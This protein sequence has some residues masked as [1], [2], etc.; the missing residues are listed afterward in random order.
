[1]QSTTKAVP[2][3]QLQ[4]ISLLL[5]NLLPEAHKTK[6]F[7]WRSGHSSIICFHCWEQPGHQSCGSPK[8]GS[9]SR[10]A[11]PRALSPPYSSIPSPQ[12][13]RCLSFP[14]R[15]QGSAPVFIAFSAMFCANARK[16]STAIQR[17][18]LSAGNGWNC[19]PLTRPTG[20]SP[21]ASN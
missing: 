20:P 2:F 7:K 15:R 21:A 12:R 10:R 14:H 9:A 1:M 5:S 13:R 8:P 18:P 17:S 4:V 3:K 16:P 11:S 19:P 6:D